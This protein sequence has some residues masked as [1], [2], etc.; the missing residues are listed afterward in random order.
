MKKLLLS[1]ICALGAMTGSAMAQDCEIAFGSVL[2]LT[3]PNAAI[4]KAIGD[5]GQLAVDQFNEA[6]GAAGCKVRYV[7]RDDQGQPNVGVDAAKSLVEIDGSPVILGSIASGVTLP[8]L[9]SVAVPAKVTQISCCSSAPSLTELAAEGGT[10]GLWFRTLPTSRPQGIVMATLAHEAGLK[11]M[12]IVYVNSD[13]GVGLARDFKEAFE[14]LGGTV[15]QMIA[16]NEQQPSY[17][18]EV[19]A[20]LQGE[21][22]AMFL[23]AFPADGATVAR[24][25]ISF[26][27]SSKLYLSN[28]MR[29]DE[30]V[31]AVGADILVDAVGIDNAQISGESVSSFDAAWEKRFGS[32]PNGPGLHTMYDATAVALL[33]MEK[34]GKPNGRAIADNIRTVT[35]GEGEVI[36]PG[37]EGFTRAKQLVAENKPF[38]YVGATGPITFDANGDVNGPYLIWGVKDGKLTTIDTWD[39]PRVD[40]ATAAIEK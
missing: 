27:G 30:F 22:E 12:A 15:S 34:A 38:T 9:T 7:L 16:Y 19:N 14:K 17:R 39:I 3:G 25:W 6:G 36:L 28:A 31:H 8:I 5:A 20:A 35:G 18:V 23:V 40:A 24:E 33:A 2:S 37:V 32:A 4:G 11:T 21:P 13:Y 10:D 29:A 1:S 26:G